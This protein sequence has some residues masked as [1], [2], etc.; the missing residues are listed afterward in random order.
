MSPASFDPTAQHGVLIR[1][2]AK[3]FRGVG[4]DVLVA[5]DHVDLEVP[6]GQVVALVGSNGAG[7]STLLSI[8][9]GS[10]VPDAGS[11]TIR[12]RDLT[13]LPSWKRVGIVARVRQNPEHNVLPTLTIEENFSLATAAVQ[14]R[15]GWGRAGG[16]RV[17]DIA[18]RGLEPFGL[19]LEDRLGV[20]AG[21][22]SGG[23]RQAVA[24]AMATLGDP[25]VLLLDEHV[26]ALDPKSAR[27]VSEETERVVRQKAITTLLVTH[28]MRYALARSD[29]LLMLHR[30]R[31]VLDLVAEEKDALDVHGLVER[32]EALTGEEVPDRTLLS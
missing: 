15:F 25:D 17:R 31:V 1:D 11:V 18:R 7:K 5:L 4:R 9:G 14:G 21:T 20:L 28:D 22:L 16:R 30:G 24:V 27:L 19:G 23:Q 29:R 3:R 26:A 12:G 8:I 10:L 2:C 13:Q 6:A 32:F